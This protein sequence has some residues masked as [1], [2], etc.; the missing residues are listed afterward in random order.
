MLRREERRSTLFVSR[1]GVEGVAQIVEIGTAAV[2]LKEVRRL[3]DPSLLEI[4]TGR[5]TRRRAEGALVNTWSS[6]PTKSALESPGPLGRWL[7][8]LFVPIA[9]KALGSAGQAWLYDQDVN[10]NDRVESNL[11]RRP[12]ISFPRRRN[13]SFLTPLLVTQ[14]AGPRERPLCAS[15]VVLF[16]ER[17]AEIGTGGG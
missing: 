14:F 16:S 7:D 12:A 9:L 4:R 8:D 2:A 11:V 10:W 6:T 13:V 1:V 17:T 3:L 5:L 15:V